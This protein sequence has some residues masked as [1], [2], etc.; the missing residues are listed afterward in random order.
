MSWRVLAFFGP[1]WGVSQR[2][3]CDL[4]GRVSGAGVVYYYRGEGLLL[5]RLR[6]L[7][8]R[9]LAAAPTSMRH[10]RQETG[11]EGC[12]QLTAERPTHG[13]IP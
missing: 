6:H 10:D 9:Y 5:P 2:G 11:Q 7:R 3:N 13:A 12:A 4:L 8:V 1:F